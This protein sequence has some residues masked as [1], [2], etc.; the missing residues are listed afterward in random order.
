VTHS[1]AIGPIDSVVAILK[2]KK[3]KDF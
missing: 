2:Q 3:C 1:S